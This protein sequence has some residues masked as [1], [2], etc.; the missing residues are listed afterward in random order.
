MYG[1]IYKT[2]NLFNGKIYVGQH[3]AKKFNPNY[4]GSGVRFSNVFEKYGKDSFTCEVL[5][6]CETEDEL[7][8]KEIYWISKLNSTDKSIGY[9]L[10]S[11]GYKI[12]GI[13][14][15]EETK[16]KISK[17][18]TGIT[19]NRDSWIPTEETKQKISNTLKE[20]Y[21]T[22]DNPRKGV[23]LS[24]ETKEK[25]R[26]VNLGKTYSEEVKDKHRNRPAWNKGI[27]M[28]EEAKQHLR[29]VNTGKIVKRRTVGQYDMSN[30]LI[31]TFIS[32]ADASRKTGVNR[33][34]ITKCCLGYIKSAN[35]Y[36]W[37]YLD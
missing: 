14:H 24:D 31:S 33:T 6:W 37:K 2:T 17:A 7:N 36:K 12:R 10:M 22:H 27:P 1:Y 8:E 21:K 30:N 34:R 32:C 11:G 15:S 18:K 5:E 19:P 13:E 35:G 26:Q 25:L 23:H 4:Y 20:F 3:R 28:T 29:E 9:N 16:E